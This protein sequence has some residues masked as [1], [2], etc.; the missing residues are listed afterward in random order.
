MTLVVVGK[1]RL[2]TL[3][4]WTEEKFKGVREGGREVR[5]GIRLRG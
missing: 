1:D 5:K 3:Q 4:R 2:D